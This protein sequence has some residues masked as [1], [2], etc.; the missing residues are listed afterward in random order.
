MGWER[1]DGGSLGG[2]SPPKDPRIQPLAAVPDRAGYIP[3]RAARYEFGAG[4]CYNSFV[5]DSRSN[6][7]TRPPSPIGDETYRRQMRREVYLPLGGGLILVAALVAFLW[8]GGVGTASGW[9]DIAL[10]FVLFPV[11]IL[12]LILLLF[13]AGLTYSIG[14]LVGWIPG[15][16]RRAQG[17]VGRVEGVVRKASRLAVRPIMAPRAVWRASETALRSLASIFRLA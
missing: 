13:L 14:A 12:G 11:M 16:T 2:R 7:V 6:H 5:P 15:L 9:A 17:I 10:V 1:E 3:R 4:A 8:Q